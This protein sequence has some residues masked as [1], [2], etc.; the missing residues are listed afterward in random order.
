[1]PA[2]GIQLRLPLRTLGMTINASEHRS[3][4]WY[5][6]DAGSDSSIRHRRGL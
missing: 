6:A 3:V 2:E 4:N 1:M 5:G